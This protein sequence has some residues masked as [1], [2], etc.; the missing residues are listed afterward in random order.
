[1]GMKRANS[2]EW[3]KQN[4]LSLAADWIKE[5]RNRKVKHLGFPAWVIG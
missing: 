5:K 1:L 4:K 2:V 3:S